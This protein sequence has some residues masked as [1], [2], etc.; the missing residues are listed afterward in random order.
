MELSRSELELESIVR[1]ITTGEL[2]LQ[3]DFQRGEIWDL[4]R[5]Q[6]L[7]DSLL[8]EWYVPAIHIVRQ[9][10]GGPDIVLDG[11]QRLAAIRDYFSD[12]FAVDGK[13]EPASELIESLHGLKYSQLPQYARR[14][15]QRFALPCVTLRGYEPQEPNE[16]F[17]RLNQSYNLTPPEKRNALHGRA[18]L[19]VKDIVIQFQETG[20]LDPVIIGF[21]NG[22]LAYDD[23]IA[24]TC[25]AVE[26]G[27]LKQ[28]LF[29]VGG[30][31]DLLPFCD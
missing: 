10:D 8:R 18:R 31:V 27:D 13:I 28:Q 3:P 7:I 11:Q 24:R 22:R 25:L 1:R 19:Q 5:R 29:R 17:F 12:K 20:L 9:R 16:L 2:D 21:S 26:R 30:L 14:I 4:K 15:L 6:R 23:I